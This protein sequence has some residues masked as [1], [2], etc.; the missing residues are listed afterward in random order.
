MHCTLN[1][2]LS[3]KLGPILSGPTMSLGFKRAKCMANRNR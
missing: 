3:L 1:I 2:A